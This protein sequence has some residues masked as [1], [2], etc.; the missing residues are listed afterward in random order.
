MKKQLFITICAIFGLS[1]SGCGGPDAPDPDNVDVDRDTEPVEAP[2]KE[3]Q[4]TEEQTPL[5]EPVEQLDTGLRKATDPE[6]FLQAREGLQAEGDPF[7]LFP[8]SPQQ[9]P[10]KIARLRARRIAEQQQQQQEQQQQEQQQQAQQQEQPQEQAEQQPQDKEA[11]E[12]EK[13]EKP[14]KP[15]KS[16]KPEPPPQ[17]K[18][19][20]DVEVVGAVQVGNDPM[21]IIKAPNERTTRYVR[22]GQFIANEQVLIKEINMSNRPTPTVVLQQIGFEQEVVKGVGKGVAVGTTQGVPGSESQDRVPAPPPKQPGQVPTL[23]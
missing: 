2:D 19:A 13:P 17:P 8:L 11:G 22:P 15:E 16:E 20:Q 12:T 9:S 14:E 23:R 4:Q 21:L 5:T 1:L 18:L 10:E 6:Q 3:A 7:R